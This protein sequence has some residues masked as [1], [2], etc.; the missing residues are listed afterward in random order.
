M[1]DNNLEL[2]ETWKKEPENQRVQAKQSMLP[3]RTC[4]KQF[5]MLDH[6][7]TLDIFPLLPLL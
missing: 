6:P 4:R 2:L 3:A 5:R 1:L 7:N